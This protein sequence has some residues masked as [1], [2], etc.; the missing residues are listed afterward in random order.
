MTLTPGTRIGPYEVV[1]SLGAGGM[2]EV[3]RAADINLGR[4]VAIKVL[5][6]AFA[7]DIER[8]ARFALE[9]RTLAT[10]HLTQ[11]GQALWP[12]VPAMSPSSRTGE[13]DRTRGTKAPFAGGQDPMSVASRWPA[14]CWMHRDPR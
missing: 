10:L 5:P 6:E 3:Y 8:L 13:C 9:A 1:G 12:L 2:G 4:H 7:T 14:E 11:G